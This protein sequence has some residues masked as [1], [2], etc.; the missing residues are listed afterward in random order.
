[1]ENNQIWE[2]KSYTEPPKKLENNGITV[3]NVT[4]KE[5]NLNYVKK[6]CKDIGKIGLVYLITNKI[7]YRIY[8]G[9]TTLTIEIRW[10][11]HKRDS[12]KLNYPLYQEMRM[13]GEENFNISLLETIESTNKND[14]IQKLNKLEIYYV[15][16]YESY[17]GWNK[18]GYNLTTGGGMEN[19]SEESRKKQSNSMKLRYIKN[20]EIGKQHGQKLKKL[21]QNNKELKDKISKIQIER[22]KNPLERIKTSN[23]IKNAYINNPSLKEKISE[24]HKKLNKNRPEIGYNHSIK[25][26]GKNHPLYNDK[27]YNFVNII[28]KENF[29]GT[30]FNFRKKYNLLQSK[31]SLL[32]NGKR[33]IH[34]NWMIYDTSAY[35]K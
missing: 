11:Q 12:K 35:K 15:K 33:K 20:P 14:L 13:Y 9:I 5:I 32:I 34:K 27:I 25:I 10:K 17:V 29:S 24:I 18:N 23:A 2:E 6:E 21:Y 16:K 26:S 4:M 1:M 3:P 22:Y 19:I 8:V 7:N 28:T 31:I 30:S